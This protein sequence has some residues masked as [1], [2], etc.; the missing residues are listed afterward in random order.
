MVVLPRR[1]SSCRRSDGGEGSVRRKKANH[2]GMR[3]HR[4]GPLPGRLVEWLKSVAAALV[5][6]LIVQSFLI[7]TFVITSGSMEDTLL[8]GDHLVANRMALGGRIPGTDVR[9][10]GYAEP[11][12]GDVMVIDPHHEEDM[13]VVKRIIGLP[14]DTLRMVAGVVWVNGARLRE[15]YV[16]TSPVPDQQHPDFAWQK[17]HLAPGVDPVTYTPTARSWGPI[18]VPPGHYFMMGDNR[19]SSL[20]SR[21]WG[22]LA[23]WRLEAR[24]SFLYF[25]YNKDSYRPF[26]ALR[27]IRWRR[28]LRGIGSLSAADSLLSPG[29]PA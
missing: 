8:V 13:K 5:V 10:P 1:E 12:R 25:S 18:V 17:D 11:R 26:P 22:P 9:L 21:H 2:R 7:K 28:L 15:P 3:K 24:V 27:E 29:D 20:D 19:D 23:A 4:A 16:R 6:F 14:G